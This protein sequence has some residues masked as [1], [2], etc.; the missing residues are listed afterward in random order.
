MPSSHPLVY[1]SDLERSL[2]AYAQ[3]WHLAIV[4]AIIL[5]YRAIF[6]AH[7]VRYDYSCAVSDAGRPVGEVV[8]E[9]MKVVWAALRGMIK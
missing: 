2:T 7:K 9:L 4:L 6:V 5:H 1:G 3:I 8:E